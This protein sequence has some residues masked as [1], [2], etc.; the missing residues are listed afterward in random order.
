MGGE[1][2][3]AAGVGGEAD[4]GYVADV[5]AGGAESLPKAVR[6]GQVDGGAGCYVEGG[7]G[8]GALGDDAAGDEGGGDEVL[9]EEKEKEEKKEKK[10]GERR[11]WGLED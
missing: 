11:G 1:V 9:G 4:V 7:A 3:V 2:A 8:L 10:E 6:P 5:V